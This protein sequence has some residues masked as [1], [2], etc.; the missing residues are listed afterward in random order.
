[1]FFIKKKNHKK[2]IHGHQWY[3]YN[4]ATLSRFKTLCH[5]SLSQSLSLLLP[6]SPLHHHSSSL[7]PSSLRVSP[8]LFS[9]VLSS[10]PSLS[11]VSVSLLM[12]SSLSPPLLSISPVSP[13][14]VSR[15]S[16]FSSLISL[17][18]HVTRRPPKKWE[19]SSFS[20]HPLSQS[21]SHLS[22]SIERE[23]ERYIHIY[24]YI[25]VV[26]RYRR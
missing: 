4:H 22:L 26:G 23:R 3:I 6:L 11:L 7:S 17:S 9:S 14:S 25:L 18:G 5:F 19:T 13:L 2:I 1:M 24:I 10:T 15:P 12:L 21:L 16:L 20:P 8:P